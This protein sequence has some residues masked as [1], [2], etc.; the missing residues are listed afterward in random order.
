VNLLAF[1]LPSTSGSPFGNSTRNPGRS[2]AF[3]ETDLSVNKKFITP[4]EGLNVEFRTEFYNLFNH[5]NFFLPGNISGTQGNTPTGGGQITSTF[6]P[7]IIQ[8]GLKVNY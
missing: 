6:E 3:N 5:T 7:R 8:F 1:K 2:P 4:I